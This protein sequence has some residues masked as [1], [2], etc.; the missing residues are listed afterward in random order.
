LAIIGGVEFARTISVEEQAGIAMTA[1][2]T[3]NEV[4][5]SFTTL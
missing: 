3:V 1:I 5:H 2:K 4:K